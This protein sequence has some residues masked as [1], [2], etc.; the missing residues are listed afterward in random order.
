MLISQSLN[1]FQLSQNKIYYKI[2]LLIIIYD[3][4]LRTLMNNEKN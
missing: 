1:L 2:S 3:F 4:F